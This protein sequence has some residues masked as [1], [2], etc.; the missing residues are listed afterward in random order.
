MPIDPCCKY[1][2]KLTSA[3]NIGSARQIQDAK[4]GIKNAPKHFYHLKESDF[5]LAT[6]V[7]I[8]Q[9]WMKLPFSSRLVRLIRQ[10]ANFPW[11]PV[12]GLQAIKEVYK[13][14]TNCY[15]FY[16]VIRKSST[17]LIKS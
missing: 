7:L 12:L 14:T 5:Q 13:T 16:N 9:S 4:Y 15:F 2:P 1:C 3:I 10:A 8:T 17:T 6:A 11:D